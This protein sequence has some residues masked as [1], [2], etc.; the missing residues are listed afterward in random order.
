MILAAPIVFLP[1]GFERHGAVSVYEW[2]LAWLG[3]VAFLVLF[4]VA[5][6]SW[7]RR[8]PFLWVIVPMCVLGAAYSSYV[9]TAVVFI[10]YAACIVP[11]A[12]DGRRL[13][14]ARYTTLILGVLFALG[15]RTTDPVLRNWY[16]V[17]CPAFCI[18]CAGSPRMVCCTSA[19][20]WREMFSISAISAR[21]RSESW[22]CE[23]SR[24]ASSV[25]SAMR[26][27]V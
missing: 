9:Y 12:V 27:S 20:A 23:S 22:F 26:V 13:L 24:P 2:V 10:N 25:L 11:W 17:V 16:W 14:T 19:S 5:L 18:T 15:L 8:L 21:A 1:L 3:V 6:V 7:Q 4:A